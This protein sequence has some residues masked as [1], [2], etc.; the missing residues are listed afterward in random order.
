MKIMVVEPETSL[1]PEDEHLLKAN[2]K[3]LPVG[4][5]IRKRKSI[6]AFPVFSDVYI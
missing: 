4:S 3:M 6:Q 2:R 1:N 5:G